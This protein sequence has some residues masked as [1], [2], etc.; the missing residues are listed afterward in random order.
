MRNVTIRK[1]SGTLI[2]FMVMMVI[3]SCASMTGITG[4][5]REVDSDA[6]LE[7]SKDGTFRA[8]DDMGMAVSGTYTLSDD[9]MIRF[10]VHHGDGHDEVVIVEY[11]VSEDLLTVRTQDHSETEQYMRE[12]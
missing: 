5:W 9:G 6:T 2:S 7:F 3:T 10:S 4:T 8:V 11:S 1:S 12:P